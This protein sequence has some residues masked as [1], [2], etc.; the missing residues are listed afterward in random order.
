MKIDNIR[1]IL[2]FGEVFLEKLG[3]LFGSKSF[4]EGRRGK[5]F[6]W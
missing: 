6:F 1:I 4:V 3:K 2:I 5:M